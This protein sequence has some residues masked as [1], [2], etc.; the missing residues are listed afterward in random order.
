[1][2]ADSVFSRSGSTVNSRGAVTAEVSVSATYVGAGRSPG[3][4][5][6][7]LGASGGTPDRMCLPA[8]IIC[9]RWY[10][11]A[12]AVVMGSYDAICFSGVGSGFFA[13]GTGI[14]LWPGGAGVHRQET[15]SGLGGNRPGLMR[16]GLVWRP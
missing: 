9:L 4:S 3:S 2:T 7:P 1:M 8:G 12:R 10:W 13:S 16:S 5:L 6:A 14:F 11:G 15:S